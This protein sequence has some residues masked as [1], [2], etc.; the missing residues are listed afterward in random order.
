M[1]QAL[2]YIIVFLVAIAIVVV[3]RLFLLGSYHIKSNHF[4]DSVN[5]GDRVLVNKLKTKGNPGRGRLILY[6]SPLKRDE[7]SPPLFAGRVVGMPGDVIQIGLD[8]FRV[9]GKIIP[10]A[11]MTRS[12]FRVRKDVKHNLLD[13]ME[14]LHIPLRHV[15]EDAVNLTLSMSIREKNLLMATLD[16]VISVDMVESQ[17]TIYSFVVPRKAHSLVINSPR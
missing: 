6:K 17:D 3:V 15:A 14:T 8:G 9:N 7:A 13:A 10:D 5:M 16:K 2:R 12:L 4:S 1:K 11:M